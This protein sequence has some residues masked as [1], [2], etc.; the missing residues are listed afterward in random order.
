MAA[1]RRGVAIGQAV[2]GHE[3]GR[4]LGGEHGDPA[5]GGVDAQEEGIE[6]QLAVAG[7]DD[8]AVED[9]ATR[10]APHPPQRRLQ[11]GEVAVQG[12]QVA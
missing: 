12:A 11:L 1:D 4:C 10:C 7:D 3:A 5:G 2:E 9:P 6:V 8:L